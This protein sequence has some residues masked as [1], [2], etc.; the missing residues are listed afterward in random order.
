MLE[1]F[2]IYKHHES[3]YVFKVLLY[4]SQVSGDVPVYS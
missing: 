1:Y 2:Y 3:A 4:V